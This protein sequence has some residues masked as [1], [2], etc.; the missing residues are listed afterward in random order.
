MAKLTLVKKL[1]NADVVNSFNLIMNILF[2]G[3]TPEIYDE[4]KVYNKGDVV[5]VQQDGIYKVVT[6]TKDAVTGT[7][8]PDNAQE[9][10]FTEMFKDS[11][12]L[13]QNNTQIHSKQ[14]AVSDDIATL[15]YELAGLVDNNLSLNTLYRENFRTSEHIKIVAG[16][17]VPGSIQALPGHGIEFKLAE[18]V[19]LR[20]EPNTFKIKHFIKL[21]GVPTL[22]CKLTFNALDTKPYWFNVNDALLSSDFMEIPK[23][24]FEKEKD[25]PYALDIRVIGDC[26]SG[27]SLVISDFMVVFI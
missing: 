3:K 23:S 20:I 11:S 2:G 8:N 15:L 18:P 27:S 13:L 6:I 16:M 25:I 24:E 17:H 22:G 4:N 1:A 10:V 9:I 26:P 14:E 12:I 21:S 5:I 19:P 7:W